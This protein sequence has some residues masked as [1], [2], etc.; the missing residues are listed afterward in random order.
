MFANKEYTAFKEG[1]AAEI[2]TNLLTRADVPIMERVQVTLYVDLPPRMDTSA[3]IKAAG[4]AVQL[5]GAIH[6]D[7]QIDRWVVQRV[8]RSPRGES[9]IEFQI[10]EV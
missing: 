10:E 8:G 5:S 4:D 3:I 2:R 1:M 7:N 9:R 6:N